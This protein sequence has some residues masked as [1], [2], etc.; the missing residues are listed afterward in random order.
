MF[1]LARFLTTT[2]RNTITIAGAGIVGITVAVAVAN[3]VAFEV[4][5]SNNNVVL[6]LTSS[7]ATMSGDLLVEGSVTFEGLP[8]NSFINGGALTTDA[9][10]LVSCSDDDTA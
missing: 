10:G 2:L 5:D 7:G 6:Q 9:N 8:C 4:R 3:Q 1:G